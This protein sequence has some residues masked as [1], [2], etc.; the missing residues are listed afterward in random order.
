LGQLAKIQIE[1]GPAQIS[2]EAIQRR[3]TVECNV[4]GRDLGGFVAEAQRTVL[5]QAKIPSG[6]VVEWAGQFE[7]LRR[8]ATRLTIVVPVALVLIFVLLYSTFGSIRP[9]MLIYT[10]VPMA[11]S[12]GIFALLLRRMP[13][14]ISAGVGLIALL[15]V[16]V[17]NGLV[18]VSHIRQLRLEG[19]DQRE[20]V[21]RGCQEK[22]RALLMAPLVAGLG[23]VPMAFSHGEGA[24]IQQPLAT[25][26]IGGLITSTFLTL[27]VLPAIFRW[28]EKEEVEF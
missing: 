4:R 11:I 21:M 1:E 5:Q 3:I 9:A 15:G 13:F 28:F 6:Y 26:V 23:F 16:A 12:G 2:R 8:A 18:L 19:L 14:S 7:N 10:N 17:L 22:L 24:E 20:A 25:V 27:I